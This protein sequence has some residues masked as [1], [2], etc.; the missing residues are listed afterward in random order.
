M[1][2]SINSKKE[3]NIDFSKYYVASSTIKADNYIIPFGDAPRPLN[4]YSV[5][6][7]S[8]MN[9]L[10][11]AKEYV[12]ITTPYVIVDNELMRAIENTAIRG[13]DV[14]IIIPHIPDKKI[15]YGMTKSVR[16]QLA[17]SRFCKKN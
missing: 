16:Q 7:M 2:Y 10:N 13:V 8:I 17:K 4:D 15:I 3:L 1:D 9:L 14:K 6:K 11:Q 12:Y 5:S